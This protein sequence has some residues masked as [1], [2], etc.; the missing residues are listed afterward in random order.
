MFV[1][2]DNKFECSRCGK[3]YM[4]RQHLGRH[5]QY[6]C[7]KQ[8]LFQCPLC[9]RRCKRNDMLNHHLKR[10]HKII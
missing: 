9:P 4:R 6:E 1:L 10:I 3:K 8:P 7:G 2:A 5:V